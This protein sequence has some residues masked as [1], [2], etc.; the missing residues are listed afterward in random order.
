MK[1]YPPKVQLYIESIIVGAGLV[2]AFLTYNANFNAYSIKGFIFFSL[3]AIVTDSLPVKLPRGGYVAVTVSVIYASIILFGPCVAAYV[4]VVGMVFCRFFDKH[5]EPLHKLLFNCAQFVISAGLAGVL[6]QVTGGSVGNIYFQSVIPF[7]VCA[8]TYFLVNITSVVI[9]LAFVQRVSLWGIWLTN[10]KW[11]F[12]NIITLPLLG[13]LM[14]YVYVKVGP[15]GVTV[16]FI[17]LLLARFNFK[18][19]INM[20]DNY[21]NTIEALAS[22]LD[23]KDTYTLGHSERV[24]EYATL[25]ARE[26]K[27]AEDKIEAIQHMALLH[28]V[29]KIGVPDEVLSKPGALTEEEFSMIKQHSVV[30]SKIIELIEELV[31]NKELILHHHE[32]FGGGGYPDGIAGQSIPLGARIIAVADSFDAMTSDR[33][34]RAGR[35]FA[36]AINILK[37]MSGTQFDPRVVDAF[38]HV[39]NNGE[40]AAQGYK[41]EAVL[42]IQK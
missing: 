26:M 5:K 40:K 9:V 3:L 14:A 21:F 13:I 22:A 32:R 41:Y 38:L 17:P 33:P 24:A 27:L 23:A 4:A 16:F 18:S 37:E 30:G 2:L 1:S 34:Y 35:T 8:L 11:L 42:P 25:I 28:D 15:V 39:L 19:Y 36:E 20:R 7:V 10:M 6:Y 31:D 12:P 29:G